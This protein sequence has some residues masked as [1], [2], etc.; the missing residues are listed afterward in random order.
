MPVLLPRGKTYP[1]ACREMVIKGRGA[2]GGASSSIRVLLFIVDEET[3]RNSA[4]ANM[5]TFR[6]ILATLTVAL[7]SSA[8]ASS[9]LDRASI[10]WDIRPNIILGV[11]KDAG[12]EMITVRAFDR[13]SPEHQAV[14][15]KDTLKSA[16]RWNDMPENDEKQAGLIS[17][18]RK[19]IK[20]EKAKEGEDGSKTAIARSH[21]GCRQTWHAMSPVA[22]M[23]KGDE[24]KMLQF[25]NENVKTIIVANDAYD[26]WHRGVMAARKHIYCMYLTNC[27]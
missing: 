19:F 25:T 8:L 27:I 20:A 13:L 21:V 15:D 5:P 16:V 10:K 26:W 2:T 17:F 3:T 23:G 4:T 18:L 9:M 6:W 1:I 22:S 7:V 24:R 12:H 11:A 14:L